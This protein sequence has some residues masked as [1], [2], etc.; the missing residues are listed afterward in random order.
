AS[1]NSA[2]FS[3]V[4]TVTKEDAKTSRPP[5]VKVTA[6]TKFEGVTKSL[7]DAKAGR[8][9]EV[10]G[11]TQSNGSFLAAKVEASN[12]NDARPEAEISGAVATVGA[13]SFRVKDAQGATPSVTVSNVTILDGV[14]GIADLDVGARVEVIGA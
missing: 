13:T 14:K 7:A 12:G 9:A 10:G 5:T 8:H 11:A 6:D 3:F 4:L 1:V 2:G